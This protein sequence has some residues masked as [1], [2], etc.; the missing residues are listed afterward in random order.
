MATRNR[1]TAKQIADD[2][3]QRARLARKR[4]NK[5]DSAQETRAAIIAGKTIRGM[6]DAGDVEASRVWDKMLA[7]LKRDQD[8]RVFGLPLLPPAA[9]NQPAAQPAPAAPRPA[10]AEID[11]RVSRAVKAWN[12]GTKRPQDR[13]EVRDAVIA[14]E[15]V[16]GKV[17]TVVE[18]ASRGSFGPGDGPGERI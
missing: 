11:A 14:L 4:A 1:R 15:Q 6:V 9:D 18:V 17:S 8:R 10:V 2:L 5:V 16:I 12:D 13:D 7:G 3:S